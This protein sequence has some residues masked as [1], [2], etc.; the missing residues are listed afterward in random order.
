[1]KLIKIHDNNYVIHKN[2]Y[3]QPPNALMLMYST[4]QYRFNLLYCYKSIL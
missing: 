4:L 1:M 2:Y 3:N